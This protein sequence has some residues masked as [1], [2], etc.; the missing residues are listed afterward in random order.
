MRGRKER[1]LKDTILSVRNLEV[2]YKSGKKNI[3]AVNNLSFD[4]KRGETFGLVGESGCGKSTTARAIIG[5]EKISGGQIFFDGVQI[6]GGRCRRH[7][8]LDPQSPSEA[9]LR[10]TTEIAGQARNDK[11][12]CNDYKEVCKNDDK[13]V[14]KKVQMIFQDPMSSLDPRMK[15]L[16][17]IAEGLDIHK[18]YKNKE[19]RLQKTFAV[20]KAVGL[21]ADYVNRY[22]HEFSGGQRQRISIAR[23]LIMEP[24][25]IIADEPISSLDVSIQAQIVN[26]LKQIQKEKNLTYLFIAHDLAMVKYISDRIGVMF[27]G[28]LVEL[29]P[30]QE[31]YDNPLHPYTKSLISAI[32]VPNPKTER[33]RKRIIYKP[34]TNAAQEMRWQ[35]VK[36]GHFVLEQR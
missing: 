15:A 7:C 27:K 3:K 13:E 17:I 36:D 32:P 14:R 4:I 24:Q 21:S 6:D 25:F 28:R 30:A 9:F 2:N 1:D 19:E 12:A 29:A 20:L 33:Q 16:D 26:L 5:L 31:L 10:Q 34:Q 23:V 11:G 35:E 8:G 18:L 22:P